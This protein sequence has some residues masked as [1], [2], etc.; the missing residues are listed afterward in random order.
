MDKAKNLANTYMEVEKGE[1]LDPEKMMNLIKKAV[2]FSDKFNA[3]E[4][5][6]QF[7]PAKIKAMIQK[8]KK[9]K[10]MLMGAETE[11]EVVE[12]IENARML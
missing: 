2:Q 7:D 9:M 5:S 6:L 3:A 11:S 8:A 10:Q 12:L 4:E 1:E